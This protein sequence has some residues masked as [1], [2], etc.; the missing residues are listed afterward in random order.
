MLVI[1]DRFKNVIAV[2]ASDDS[3]FLEEGDSGALV[4]Y[5]DKNDV[6]HVFAYGV[7]EV[8]GLFLPDDDDEDLDKSDD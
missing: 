4:F 2:K 6:K 7:V 8:D 1:K 3:A 5:H